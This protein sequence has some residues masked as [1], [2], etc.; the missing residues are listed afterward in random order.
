MN[1]EEKILLKLEEENKKI[2]KKLD[3]I[4]TNHLNHIYNKIEEKEDQKYYDLILSIKDLDK[5]IDIKFNYVSVIS[6]ITLIV[7]TLLLRYK[8]I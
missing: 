4:E 2:E 5:K 6:A 3:H 8:I 7:F 1:N